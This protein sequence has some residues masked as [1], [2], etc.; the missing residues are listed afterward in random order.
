MNAL[1]I[2]FPQPGNLPL[3]GEEGFS[4][5]GR[6]SVPLTGWLRLTQSLVLS[7]IAEEKASLLLSVQ[8]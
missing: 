1:Q 3:P 7:E 4:T 6:P 8:A 5:S 2:S